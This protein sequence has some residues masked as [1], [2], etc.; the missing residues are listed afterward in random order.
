MQI[1][2]FYVSRILFPPVVSIYSVTDFCRIQWRYHVPSFDTHICYSLLCQQG[3]L[4]F[5]LLLLR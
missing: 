3:L 2:C 1:C 5:D 4:P